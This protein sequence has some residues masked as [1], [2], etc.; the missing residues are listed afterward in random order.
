MCFSIR[1]SK[2]EE[3]EQTDIIYVGIIMATINPL[4]ELKLHGQ[5]TNAYENNT[6]H[7]LIMHAGS[8]QQVA[9]A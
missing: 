5:T 1:S 8:N 7:G 6:S 2:D 9:I 3:Q 4:L